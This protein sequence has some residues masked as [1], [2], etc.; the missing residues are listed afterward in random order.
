MHATAISHLPWD[1]KLAH[2]RGIAAL[3]VLVFHVFHTFFG[4]W[5]PQPGFS[6][7]GWLVEGHTGVTLFF[8]LSGYL[9]MS[10]ALRMRG[11]INYF[12]FLRNRVLRIV[13]LYTVFFVVAVSIGRDS[14]RPMDFLY[15]VFSNI[16][17]APTSNQFITGAAWTIGVEFGFYMVFPFFARFAIEQGISYL[18]RLV[19]LLLL[20]KWGAYSVS[21]HPTHM[22]YSTL[23]GR[24]D[25][26]LIGMWA[27]QLVKGSSIASLRAGLHGIWLM[28]AAIAVWAGLEIQSLSASYFLTNPVQPAWVLWPSLDALL[29]S[30]LL[31]T[32]TLWRGTFG[33]LI[34]KVLARAGE[35]S[36]SIY[37]WH[38]LV[39][40]GL[41]RALGDAWPGLLSQATWHLWAVL[42]TVIVLVFTWIIASISHKVIELPFTQLRTRYGEAPPSAA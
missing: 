34:E 10:I 13:P 15:I 3:L 25:Q 17:L 30:L 23:L 40:H 33:S 37:L 24:L 28:L 2:L 36:F 26:F 18:P 27:A 19:L 39:I 11:D 22:I 9:F 7:L 42:F 20:L 16:G 29:W 5:H 38:A 1:P 4:H 41:L 14:F 31:V 12:S 35:I 21:E 6:G 8:V 32:Y